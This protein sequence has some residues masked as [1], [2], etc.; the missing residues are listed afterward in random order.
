MDKHDLTEFQNWTRPLIGQ[1]N[2]L[3]PNYIS[4]EIRD[5]W[6]R[7]FTLREHEEPVSLWLSALNLLAFALTRARQ[8]RAGTRTRL[9]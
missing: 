4:E 2:A 8:H 1:P 5:N 9:D 7:E 3:T 6:L